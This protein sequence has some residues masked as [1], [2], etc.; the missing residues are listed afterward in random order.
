[1]HIAANGS[2]G[3][4]MFLT[5]TAGT[6]ETG[7]HLARYG[8]NFLAGWYDGASP[9]LAVVS[10][11]GGMVEGPVSIDAQFAEK[12]DFIAWPGG[13]AGWAYAWGDMTQLRIVRVSRCE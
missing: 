12:D 1:V 8:E 13:D 11:S 3:S 7:A 5:D 10:E 6:D 2:P 9:T 4:A